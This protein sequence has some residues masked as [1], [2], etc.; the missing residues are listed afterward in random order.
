VGVG[1]IELLTVD[2]ACGSTSGV[3]VVDASGSGDVI[4]DPATCPEAAA[5]VA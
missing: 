5:A 2:T 4:E 1:T 3:T